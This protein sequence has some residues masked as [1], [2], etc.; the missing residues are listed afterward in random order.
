MAIVHH[1]QVEYL[2]VELHN[3]VYIYIMRCPNGFTQHPAKSGNCVHKNTI[4]KNKKTVDTAKKT[5]KR[6]PKGTR[7][8][9][10]TGNCETF[11]KHKKAAPKKIW[12]IYKIDYMYPSMI[13][14][15]VN[16][17]DYGIMNIENIFIENEDSVAQI[18]F[19][20]GRVEIACTKKQNMNLHVEWENISNMKDLGV[21]VYTLEANTSNMNFF[22]MGNDDDGNNTTKENVRM[23]KNGVHGKY[24]QINT[25]TPDLDSDYIDSEVKKQIVEKAIEVLKSI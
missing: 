19:E 6:C 25:K 4:T 11:S 12:K 2:Q 7:K 16:S 14:V 9:K 1:L 17:S 21:D 20:D 8:N 23:I 13:D 3:F 22:G 18:T 15:A 5:P 10:K 24:V